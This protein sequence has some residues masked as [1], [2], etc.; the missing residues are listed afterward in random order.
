MLPICQVLE[1]SQ[2]YFF[3]AE[4]SDLQKCPVVWYDIRPG[5][6]ASER[7]KARKYSI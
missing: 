4:S 2:N 5:N 7:Y 1:V 3:T 6:I